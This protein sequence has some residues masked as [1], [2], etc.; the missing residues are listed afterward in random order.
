MNL[1]SNALTVLMFTNIILQSFFSFII[2][3]ANI[4]DLNEQNRATLINNFFIKKNWFVQDK[5]LLCNIYVS[6]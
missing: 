5:Y 6:K 2:D 4:Q 1:F 3:Y